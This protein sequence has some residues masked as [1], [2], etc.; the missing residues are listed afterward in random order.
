MRARDMDK[1]VKSAACRALAKVG[2]LKQQIRVR[3]KKR[4]VSKFGAVGIAAILLS[5]WAARAQNGATAGVIPHQAPPER[6]G[7]FVDVTKASGV[8]FDGQAYHTSMKYLIETMGSGVALFDY[9][10]DGRLDIFFA[11]GAPLTDPEPVGTIPKKAGPKD[12]NRLYHQKED[13]TFEDVTERAGL[14]GAGYD[15]GVAVGDYDNDGYEDLY[16]AGYGGNH[17]YHNDGNGKFTDVTGPSGTGGSGWSTSAAWVDLD[18]DGRLDLVV[19]R[20]LKWDFS[21]LYCGEHREGH[22]AYCHPDLF[23]PIAPLVYH[24]DGNGHFTEVA[25]KIGLDTPGK[26]LGI[27]IAD[28]DRDGHTDIFVAND[29][30]QEFLYHNKGNGTFEELGLPGAVAVDGDGRTFAGM[31]VDFSDY[32]NDGLPDLIITDLANQKYALYQ[33]AGDGTFN[34]SSY[35]TGL[36]AATLLHSGWGVAFLDYD[37]D[38][39]KDL[40]IAQGHDIDNIQLDYPQ[41]RYKEPLMLLHNNGKRL[42]DVSEASGEVFHEAWVGRGLATGDIWNDGHADVVITTNGGPAYILRNETPTSNHWLGIKLVGHTSN[43]DGIGAEIK[44][45]NSKGTQLVTVSTAGSYLSSHDKRAHFGL[46]SDAAA[47]SIVVRWPSGMTQTLKNVPGDRLL[48]LD[49]PSPSQAAR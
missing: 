13:G 41:L 44:V 32:N 12:W 35:L 2:R 49:E 28:Y 42:V 16:V 47:Q 46:G 8:V 4:I 14:A 9:D 10:N 34:Y 1:L 7:K 38:G 36:A 26:G 25:A 27:A 11:N 5:G 33:N 19:L 30:M 37:N 29:S 43:R 15:L 24:N 20:Y 23:P 6:P 45:T 22:R 17:L 40:I 31:G 3:M 21:D 48:V 18:N 39:W